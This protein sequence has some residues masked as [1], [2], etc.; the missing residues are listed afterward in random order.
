MKNDGTQRLQALEMW[1]RMKME[2]VNRKDKKTNEHELSAVG[3]H[4]MIIKTIATRKKNWTNSEREV[5]RCYK[6]KNRRKEKELEEEEEWG[7]GY[8]Q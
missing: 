2:R 1:I 6:R 8:A 7:G 5:L 4:R 3:E